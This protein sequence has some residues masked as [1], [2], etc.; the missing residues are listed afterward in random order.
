MTHFNGK[1]YNPAND[2]DRLKRQMVR[3]YACMIDGKWRT[4]REIANATNDPEASVS[5]QLRH[6]RK[7]RFG[8]YVVNLRS[9]GDP[10]NGLWEYQ[11]TK[12][13]PA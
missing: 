3:V 12:E 9:R 5:A 10:K 11:L 2:D 13:E 6:L 1:H 4:L 7:E 8:K